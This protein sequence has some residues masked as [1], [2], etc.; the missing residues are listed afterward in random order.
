MKNAWITSLGSCFIFDAATPSETRDKVS[1][2]QYFCV[3]PY[4]T[5]KLIQKEAESRD[6]R[7]ASLV[8]V[9]ACTV[10]KDNAWK[11]TVP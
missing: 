6:D 8:N 7:M 10:K 5:R 3:I 4:V 1:E 11:A 2:E 9:N